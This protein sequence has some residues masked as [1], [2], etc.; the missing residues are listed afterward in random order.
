VNPYSSR[1][2]KFTDAIDP[3][4]IPQRAGGAAIGATCTADKDCLQGQCEL[5]ICV[6]LCAGGGCPAGDGCYAMFAQLT[7]AMPPITGCLPRRGL[8]DYSLGVNGPGVVGV[9]E[10]A[11][12]LSLWT[13]AKGQDLSYFAGIS[14]ITDPDGNQLYS[15]TAQFLDNT[16]RYQFAEGAS[17]MQV[18][19]SPLVKLHANGVYN[20]DPLAETQQGKTTDFETRAIVKLYEAPLQ[21]AGK[22]ALHVFITDLTGACRRFD[23]TS[24]PSVLGM[25]ETRLRTIFQQAQITIDEI[26][27]F[28][29]TAPNTFTQSMTGVSPGLDAILQQATA[30]DTPNTLELVVL[31]SIGGGTADFEVLGTAGGIPG[32]AGIPGTVHSGAVV[33]V[34]AL[35]NDPTQR[36]L[37]LTAGHELGHVLGLF[38]SV[39]QDGTKDQMTDNDSDGTANLMY[40]SE[41]SVQGHLS[42]QQI[43][44]WLANP[45]V[46]P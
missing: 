27:Y 23:A 5:G 18:S 42:G 19:N 13:V 2:N 9:P 40:W 38:H 4:C 25:F 24:A 36:E 20:F 32:A 16:L 35:C 1:G 33:S 11:I 39:E 31:R 10:N 43:A 8:L 45:V 22:I 41:G 14:D 21:Q 3:I 17:M 28:D 37:A 34:S 6:T 44:V 12:S 30:G 7:D 46:R 26:K 15:V 29:S